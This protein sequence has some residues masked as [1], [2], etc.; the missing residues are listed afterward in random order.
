MIINVKVTTRSRKSDVKVSDGVYLVSLK[1]LP[2]KNKANIEL[3]NTLSSY[4][5]V[6]KSSIKILRGLKSRHK[7]VEIK[8]D[9]T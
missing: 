5:N 9:D 7:L 2:F 3:I 1:S 6:S 4:F 8:Q